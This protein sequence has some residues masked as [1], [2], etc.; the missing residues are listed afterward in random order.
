MPTIL[1]GRFKGVGRRY[2]GTG[3]YIPRTAWALKMSVEAQCYDRHL[4]THPFFEGFLLLLVFLE[5]LKCLGV[6]VRFTWS[7]SWHAILFRQ[8]GIEH[9]LAL[10]LLIYS[11][12]NPFRANAVFATFLMLHFL[13]M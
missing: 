10:L 8:D 9:Q 5:R 2:I 11:I 3:M 13:F 4:L 1:Q 6:S 7:K 12:Y